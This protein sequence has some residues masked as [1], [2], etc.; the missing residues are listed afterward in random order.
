MKL[1]WELIIST[2]LVSLLQYGWC[3]TVTNSTYN[4][5]IACHTCSPLQT[6]IIFC[7]APIC[8]Y[9]SPS[10]WPQARTKCARHIHALTTYGLHF[11]IWKPIINP[12]KSCEHV[13]SCMSTVHLGM[14]LCVYVH[15][16]TCMCVC[17]QCAVA[18]VQ[19]AMRVHVVC[20]A[21]VRVVCCMCVYRCI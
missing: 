14:C 20:C 1:L 7:T 19:C 18:C 10:T 4:E 13:N 17:M 8:V 21:C 16:C 3:S 12:W 11:T 9:R 15:A 2:V 6:W 5:H